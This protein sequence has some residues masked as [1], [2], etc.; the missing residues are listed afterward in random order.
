MKSTRRSQICKWSDGFSRYGGIFS[1]LSVWFAVMIW[2]WWRHKSQAESRGATGQ[3]QSVVSDF[4]VPFLEGTDT[5]VQLFLQEVEMKSEQRDWTERVRNPPR[6]AS[7]CQDHLFLFLF[8]TRSRQQV[9]IQWRVF[10]H[11]AQQFFFNSRWFTISQTQKTESHNIYF[12][13]GA[14]AKLFSFLKIALH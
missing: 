2:R 14:F 8:S 1:L 10:S 13:D 7:M 5:H 3:C 11:V 9:D 6:H 12:L 4:F